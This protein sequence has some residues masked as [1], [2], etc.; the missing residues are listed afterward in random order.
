MEQ[1]AVNSA[2]QVFA[3]VPAGYCSVDCTGSADITLTADQAAC[4][5]INLHGAIGAAINVIV[6][7]TPAFP[8]VEGGQAGFATLPTWLKYFGNRTTGNFALTIKST[9]GTGSTIPGNG[10]NTY[11]WRAFDGTNVVGQVEG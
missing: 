4:D 3:S 1:I 2:S 8:M 11:G 6:P 10:T 9:S 7:P 5:F